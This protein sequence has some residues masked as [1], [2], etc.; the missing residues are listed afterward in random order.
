M[1][2][3]W[4]KFREYLRREYGRAPSFIAVLE[5]TKAG[6]PHLHVLLDR[7]IDQ[8]WISRT[9]DRLGGG[10]ICFIKQVKV[11]H[12]ARYLSKYLSKELL[13]APKG[14]RRLTSSRSIKLFPKWVGQR[15]TQRVVKQK[16][17]EPAE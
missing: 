10:R 2:Q 9:W 1:R 8:G 14:S 17:L 4:N 13:L 16:C 5:F 12:V 6:L 7:W 15:T 3:I 11:V